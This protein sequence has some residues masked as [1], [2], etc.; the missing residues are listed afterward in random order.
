LTEYLDAVVD[1]SH[2]QAK[3]DFVAM[4]AGGVAA[5]ILKATQGVSWVDKTFV[6]RY[7]EA[8]AAGLLVGAY[9]FIDASDPAQQ[10]EHF[11]ALA[12][13]APRLAVD[14]EPNGMAG[15]ATIEQAA[16]FIAMLHSAVGKLPLVY[17]GRYG[18]DGKGTGL[19][20]SVLMQ[21]PLWLPEYGEW[22]IL[23]LNWKTFTLWQY[24]E[25]GA[26]SG[27]VGSCD[28]SRYNGTLEQLTTWWAT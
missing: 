21:C 3:V 6:Q 20:N 1:L 11:L 8:T 16:T 26:A 14:I 15:T 24:T 17:V 28:R 5:V 27:V 19:P 13:C 23:P 22:P 7:H 25:T 4:K 12:N 2:W 18:V 10:V 9:H